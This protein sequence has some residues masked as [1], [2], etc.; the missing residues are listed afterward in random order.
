MTSFSGK[1][2]SRIAYLASIYHKKLIA[3]VGKNELS[4]NESLN[5]FINDVITFNQDEKDF[6]LIKAH[7]KENLYNKTFNYFKKF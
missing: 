5:H 7:T 6:D 4:K 2:V 1:V 3:I